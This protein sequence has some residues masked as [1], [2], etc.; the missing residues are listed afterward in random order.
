MCKNTNSPNYLFFFNVFS[1][2]ASSPDSKSKPENLTGAAGS[3]HELKTPTDEKNIDSEPRSQISPSALQQPSTPT[4]N[5]LIS[6]KFQWD[7]FHCM[8]F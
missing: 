2:V 8:R 4:L 7:P 6:S 3:E 1:I 5:G